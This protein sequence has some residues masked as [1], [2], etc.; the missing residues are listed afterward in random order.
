M[1]KKSLKYIFIIK[2][3]VTFLTRNAVSAGKNTCKRSNDDGWIECVSFRNW[4][5]EF[6][7]LYKDKCIDS[8]RILLQE[9]QQD[10]ED[11]VE[12]FVHYNL[13]S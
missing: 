11:D 4:L 7:S 13:D 9:K 8:G 6:C 12:Y 3:R 5:H 1:Q 2:G 10:E